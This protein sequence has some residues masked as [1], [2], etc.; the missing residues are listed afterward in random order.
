M[1]AD[2]L[3]LVLKNDGENQ[4][5]DVG[6]CITPPTNE[7]TPRLVCVSSV[8]CWRQE[9][10]RQW[11]ERNR[12]ALVLDEEFVHFCHWQLARNLSTYSELLESEIH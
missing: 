3:K 1:R 5:L 4:W 8:C 2:E 10:R 9:G 12:D 11:E 6:F 7:A